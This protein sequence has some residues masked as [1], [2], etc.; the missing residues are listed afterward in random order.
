[1]KKILL[2]LLFA[3]TFSLTVDA[4]PVKITLSD[5]TVVYLESDDFDTLEDMMAKVIL[6]EKQIE[7]NAQPA[8]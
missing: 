6:L 7:Q 1:M 5:G 8:N 2:S 3:T 4:H